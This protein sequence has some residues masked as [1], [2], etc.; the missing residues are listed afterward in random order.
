MPKKIYINA[1]IVKEYGQY[2]SMNIAIKLEELDE[3]IEQHSKKGW[4][5]LIIHKRKEPT[6]K[7]IT[8]YV[9]LDEYEPENKGDPD[10]F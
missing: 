6:D 5:N 7:G 3:A 8:H 10:N 2:G 1:I 9:V 4:L